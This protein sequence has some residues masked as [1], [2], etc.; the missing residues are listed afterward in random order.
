MNLGIKPDMKI[1]IPVLSCF[2][3]TAACSHSVSDKI[4]VTGQATM[5]VVPDIVELTLKSYNVRPAMKDA[6]AETQAA[7]DQI[8]VVCNKYIHDSED[9]K[10]SNVATNKDYDYIRNREI[11]KG[12]SAQQVL[13]VRLK[14]IRQ[15]EKFTADL[16][17]T[18]ITSIECVRYDHSR[19]DS[20][21]RVVNLLA[22]TDARKTAENMCEKMNV[23][24]GKTIFL[25]NYPP[26]GTQMGGMRSSENEY[27][28]NL[29]S[30]SFG[31]RGFK[32]TAEILEF[33]DIAFA[34]F[35]I[36][37]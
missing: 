34:G 23:T 33:Q 6:V 29:Y 13:E 4:Q 36:K 15:I 14:D 16:L 11:F 12:Y 9:I 25:S 1:Y 27:E 19:A 35:E 8:L 17:A 18:K 31:G 7:I 37:Q 28:L 2:I 5:K 26:G 20:I 22:L 21:Q 10:V 32:M 24:L 30:K 3:L